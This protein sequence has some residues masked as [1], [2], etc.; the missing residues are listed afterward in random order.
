MKVTE[1]MINIAKQAYLNNDSQEHEVWGKIGS[2]IKVALEAVFNHVADTEKE[3]EAQEL[4]PIEELE[5]KIMGLESELEIVIDQIF[6]A[7]DLYALKEITKR[8]FPDKWKEFE[9][10]APEK[11]LNQQETVKKLTL[12]QYVAAN[13]INPDILTNWNII[14]IISE[15]L[16]KEHQKK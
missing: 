14:D 10:C 7:K 8:N 5:D 16:A 6:T 4:T 11:S 9:F 3:V 15:Y 13:I 1:E 12:S 2:N